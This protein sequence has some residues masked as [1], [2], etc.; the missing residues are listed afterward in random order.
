MA[1]TKYQLPGVDNRTR[2]TWNHI[3]P[4]EAPPLPLE[5]PAE[6]SDFEVEDIPTPV[7]V[8]DA[9][10]VRVV[11][12]VREPDRYRDARMFQMDIRPLNGLAIPTRRQRQRLVLVNT[13]A[14]A[15]VY[16]GHE[17]TVTERT[18]FPLRPADPPLDLNAQRSYY[19][20][21]ADAVET[22]I[23]GVMEEFITELE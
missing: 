14:S 9:V 19:L 21:N 18:G 2:Q 12:F 5:L 15:L 13:H 4:Y 7:T 3:K 10:P 23:V 6:D 11:E 16:I 1:K 17:P 8:E 22:V 20:Y